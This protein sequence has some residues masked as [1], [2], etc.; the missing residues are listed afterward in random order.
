[1]VLALTTPTMLLCSYNCNIY[2]QFELVT[3]QIH[4]LFPV[5]YCADFP[6]ATIWSKICLPIC[7]QKYK[8]LN[9]H[10]CSFA[11]FVQVWNLPFILREDRRLRLCVC[12]CVC[13]CEWGSED[14]IWVLC[15]DKTHD[16]YF[17]WLNRGGWDRR[18]KWQIQG[19]REMH[20][21]FL[22]EN[23]RRDHLED[24]HLDVGIIFKW[25]NYKFLNVI[26]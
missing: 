21:V 13:V 22:L 24:L 4:K 2:V 26:L 1:L 6:S 14:N 3:V 16:L 7:Y 19:R 20:A 12:V 15:N 11:S 23:W 18:Y 8:D 9:T 25:I 10:N 17:G 5:L